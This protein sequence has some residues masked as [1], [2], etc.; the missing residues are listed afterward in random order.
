M[1]HR[2]NYLLHS[3]KNSK[4]AYYL[5][6]YAS[7]LVPN[8]F[9]RIQ[10]ERLLSQIERRE[11]K[12]YIR[13]RIDYYCQ[14]E[15]SVSLSASSPTIGEQKIP[16]KQKVYF[17][18]SREIVR[19]FDPHLRW[20]LLPGDIVHV[21]DLPSIVK[22]RPLAGAVRNSTLLKMDKVRHFI[23]VKDDLSWEDKKPM[24]IFRGKVAG[25][26]SRM[27]FMH[28]YFGSSVCDCGD[29]SRQGTVPA[30]WQTGKKTIRDHLQYRYI[31][32][33]EGNDVASNLKWVMSSNSIA[34]MPRPTCETWFMEGTL[35]PDYHYIEIKPDFSDLEQRLTFYNNHPEQARQIIDHAHTYVEQF[36][37]KRREQL[38]ALGVMDKY[39]RK[40]N[41][42][43][44]APPVHR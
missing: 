35:I 38:I 23:F 20:E 33:L 30:E 21:P 9:W 13:Q 28:R 31:M 40:V 43:S 42:S 41:P 3:G 12:E 15:Q 34:V 2:L 39:L 17:F 18:D 10:R 8:G 44:F 24:A 37:D 4:L 26:Q 19:Y 36:K 6:G 25:K 11:D 5:R 14:L 32:A 1:I 16:K 29:V 22:S 7:L 27:D